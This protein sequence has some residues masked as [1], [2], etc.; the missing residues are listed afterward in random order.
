[1]IKKFLLIIGSMK[2]GTTSL[3]Y[4]LSEHPSICPCKIKEPNFFANHEN[5]SKGF[6]WYQKLWDFKPDRHTIAME[7]ST[8]YTKIPLFPN[9]AD[10]I[11]RVDKNIEFKFIYIMRNPIDRIESHYTHSLQAKWGSNIK[12]IDEDINNQI[13]EVSKYAKQINEYFHRFSPDN[14]LLLNFEDLRNDP[15]KLLENIC[16]FLDID[17]FF[18]FSRISNIR[19]ISTEKYI[20]S[21]TWSVIEPIA[22]HLPLIIQNNIRNTLC[23]KI[24]NK[25]RISH[26]QRNFILNELHDDLYELNS[27]YGIDIARWGLE[28]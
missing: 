2:C 10:F 11:S 24:V 3:F 14:I 5:L 16:N 6:N 9:A 23:K 12:P 13:I 7:S 27:K 22:Q 21:K 1:M 18:K 17:P 28:I 20:Y 4:Y 15:L 25:L 26:E 8:H 19:N